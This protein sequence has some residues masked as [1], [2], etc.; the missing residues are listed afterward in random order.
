MDIFRLLYLEKQNKSKIAFLLGRKP[1]TISRELEKGMDKGMY[2]PL[3]AEMAHLK[4]RRY[5]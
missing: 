2:N 1:S 3:M 5:Q 4:A